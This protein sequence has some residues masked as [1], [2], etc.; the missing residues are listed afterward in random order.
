MSL[1]KPAAPQLDTG[2]VTPVIIPESQH[3]VVGYGPMQIGWVRRQAGSLTFKANMRGFQ[4]WGPYKTAS[5]AEAAVVKMW[6]DFN[7]A[8]ALAKRFKDRTRGGFAVKFQHQVDI[9]RP[10]PIVAAIKGADGR[11]AATTFRSDGTCALSD[12]KDWDLILI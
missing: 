8:P 4:L 5:D 7:S 2:P 9:S 12:Q 11:W 1:F 6:T 3:Q 10:D